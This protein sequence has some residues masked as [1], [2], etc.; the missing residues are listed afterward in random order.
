MSAEP[1]VVC[2]ECGRSCGRYVIGRNTGRPRCKTCYVRDPRNE[3]TI[4][5]KQA[6]AAAV[7]ALEPRLSEK[8]ILDCIDKATSGL[9]RLRTL[10]RAVTEV[11]DV[12]VGSS[13][14]PPVVYHVVSHLLQAGAKNV[15]L[16]RCANCGARVP[17]GYTRGADRI[18]RNCH[19]HLFRQ[20]ECSGCGR[21]RTR[22]A[23]TRD[24][25][26]LCAMC[27]T[28][29]Q[30]KWKRCSLC[31][32][33]SRI[34]V[35]NDD[36]SFICRRCY[37]RPLHV[38]DKCGEKRGIA[39]R[40]DG[41]AVCERC[42]RTPA[43][44][45]GACERV[46]SISR[47]ATGED[48]DL[49]QY[50]AYLRVA[51]CS[52][53]GR[54]ERC[55]GI[56]EGR[57][58]CLRCHLDDTVTELLTGP[59]GSIFKPLLPLRDTILAV[60]DPR[61]A[62]RWLS[63]TP[64]V[65]VIKAFVDGSLALT[66]EALDGLPASTSLVHLRDL[67]IAC[68]ALPERDPYL[69]RLERFIDDQATSLGHAE[70]A[71]LLKAFGTW[72]VLRKVRQLVDN[73]RP[74]ISAIDNGKVNVRLAAQFIKWLHDRG[75]GVADSRQ[76][77]LDEW[78][79]GGV[80]NRF[81]VRA[82]VSWAVERHV[83]QKVS[84]PPRAKDSAAGPVDLESRIAMARRLLHDDALDP[85][86]RVA[87]ALVVIYG[88]QASRIVRLKTSDVT[89]SDGNT[90]IRLGTEAVLIPEPLGSLVRALP[91]RR[92]VGVSGKAKPS[93]WLFP[94]RQAG[95][96]QHPRNMRERLNNIGIE[97]RVTRNA[98][99][100]QLAAEVPAAV[101]ADMLGMHVHTAT[102]WVDKVAGNWTDYAALKVGGRCPDAAEERAE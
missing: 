74:A 32:E 34:S 12:L 55:T 88:Q 42:Y 37:E 48:P 87:G 66:H 97:C 25:Q 81:R 77:D 65:V 101:L 1:A 75:K 22:L 36:G 31:G 90:F 19:V 13:K 38:C 72:R 91:W 14:A 62:Q 23:R 35:R 80:K 43:R 11:P 61:S 3:E 7:R 58:I 24:G 70:D 33:I 71:R 51:L 73:G 85:A 45:C 99:L 67:L 39:S 47:R 4:T 9:Y 98:A 28:H 92:Q 57:P 83:M 2:S 86:D 20:D 29:D 79:A 84:V 46:R 54:E 49:C 21:R 82:F 8:A 17:L 56:R 40:K 89:E 26:P 15:S 69:A 53:C 30:T 60:D 59:D 96:H 18:C 50:C 44:R 64:A 6:V 100:T 102:N 41:T 76:A 63:Y 94:G 52:R 93:E 78:L 5:K 10:A 27:Y 16:P 68:G 95:R